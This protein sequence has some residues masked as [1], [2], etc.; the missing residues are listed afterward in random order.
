MW[1]LDKMGMRTRVSKGNGSQF[2]VHAEE[3]SG[4]SIIQ[5]PYCGTGNG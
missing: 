5:F 1:T 4:A 2:L 3:N